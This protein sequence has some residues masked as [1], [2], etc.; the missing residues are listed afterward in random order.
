MKDSTLSGCFHYSFDK[1]RNDRGQTLRGWLLLVG[2]FLISN[3]PCMKKPVTEQ[4]GSV[5]WRIWSP[6]SNTLEIVS[7]EDNSWLVPQRFN[8]GCYDAIQ[9]VETETFSN[10][11]MHRIGSNN[12]R[13]ILTLRRS[14]FSL[15]KAKVIK[16]LQF[17]APESL[18][19]SSSD[20]IW[21]VPI[22]LMQDSM[23]L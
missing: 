16:N 13:W 17:G 7:F 2:C 22:V 8:Q 10:L 3:L 4:N 11:I 9:L 6:T 12:N 15:G 21:N 19:L 23:G 1:R 5:L 14:L 20:L 18:K